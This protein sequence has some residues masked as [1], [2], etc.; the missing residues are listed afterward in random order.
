MTIWTATTVGEANTGTSHRV[1]QLRLFARLGLFFIA[2]LVA[3]GVGKSLGTFQDLSIVYWPP[4]GVLL[5]TLL[6]SRRERWPWFIAMGLLAEMSANRVWFHNR[7]DLA[8]VYFAANALEGLTAAFLIRRFVTPFRLETMREIAIF[9]GF[10]VGVAPVVGAT[11]IAS[12][13]TI[14]GKHEFIE[15]WAHVWLGDGVGLLATTPLVYVTVREWRTLRVPSGARLI[16]G[17]LLA[18]ILV[19]VGAACFQGYLVTMYFSLPVLLW[20]AT[21]FQ[22]RG[23]VA[24]LLTITVLCGGFA[25]AREGRFDADGE[26]LR[27]QLV[28]AQVF[29]GVSFVST[30]L[31]SVLSERY[32]NALEALRATNSALEARVAERTATLAQSEAELRAHRERLEHLVEERTRELEES[33]RRLSL[34][35]RMAA[36]GTLSAGLGHDMANILVPMRMSLSNLE[37]SELSEARREDV[38]VLARSSDYLKSLAVGL[39]MLSLDPEDVTRDA[40]TELAQW[41]SD[42]ATIFKAILPRT[43]ELNAEG[44][45]SA[46]A[47]AMPAHA[48]TQAVFNLIQNAGDAMK[49]RGGGR[50]WVR[51][52]VRGKQVVLSVQDDGPGMTREVVARCME[53]FFTT[54]TRGR[55]TGLGLAIVYRV[56]QRFGGSVEVESELGKGTQFRLLLPALEANAGGSVLG[57]LR[58]QDARTRAVASALLTGRGARIAEGMPTNGDAAVLITDGSASAGEVT[59]FLGGERRGIV[60][61]GEGAGVMAEDPR[62]VRIRDGR[63]TAVRDAI[64]AVLDRLE[65]K[66]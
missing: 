17:S 37:R 4:A 10:G 5:G 14:I 47:I 25:L 33:L 43:I 63:V 9:A 42:A 30:L 27:R 54:K 65:A 22:L 7:V 66:H 13:D 50:V 11:I 12:V 61:F 52:V 32:L 46:P 59:A 28:L 45:E 41:W 53:P 62:V 31:V 18:I 23:G 49:D 1:L 29:L 34:S 24:A 16:E 21:R 6:L 64:F 51:C 60:V 8:C 15:A 56:L 57:V 3:A 44:L 40:R 20:A 38:Q 19:S 48:L 2:Y 55:G 58:V 26:A 35:E 39:R 36:L